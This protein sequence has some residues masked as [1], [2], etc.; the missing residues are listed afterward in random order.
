MQE[1][2]AYNGVLPDSDAYGYIPGC[3]NV[4][5]TWDVGLEAPYCMCP[6]IVERQADRTKVEIEVILP[7]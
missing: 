4:S 5:K 3:S 7:V 6:E 2:G 1:A